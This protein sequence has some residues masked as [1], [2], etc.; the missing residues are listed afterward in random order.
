MTQLSLEKKK[1]IRDWVF[2]IG[3]DK[4]LKALHEE[5]DKIFINLGDKDGTY[6]EQRINRLEELV[7]G[8]HYIELLQKI[9][10]EQL[11]IFN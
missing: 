11:K 9:G 3:Y 4:A 5:H 1:V 7:E 10:A 6:N 2:Q 8:I